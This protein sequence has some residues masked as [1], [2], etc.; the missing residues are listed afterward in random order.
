MG[1]GSAVPPAGKPGMAIPGPMAMPGG[2]MCIGMCMGMAPC[3]ICGT[4]GT[5][6]GAG[7]AAAGRGGPR[8]HVGMHFLMV[9]KPHSD[10]T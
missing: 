3:G 4:G 8:M 9:S 10:G 1:M 6:V 7:Q 5:G 2:N